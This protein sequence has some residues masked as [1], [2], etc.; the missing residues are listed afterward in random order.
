MITKKW[1]SLGSMCVFGTEFEDSGYS[2]DVVKQMTDFIVCLSL[3]K[4]VLELW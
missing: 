3:K 2:I 1:I 4:N